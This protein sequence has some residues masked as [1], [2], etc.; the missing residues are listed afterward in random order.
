MRTASAAFALLLLAAPEVCAQS[1][2]GVRAWAGELSLPTTIEG[3][4]NPNPPFD[5]FAVGRFNYPYALRDALTAR[6]HVVRYRALFLEN[7]FLK[8]TVLPELGGH[9]YSCLDKISGREMFYANRSIK[10]RGGPRPAGGT[11][12]PRPSPWRR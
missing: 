2:A 10:A 11:R 8:I 6:Q 12:P 9:L 1:A 4:A 7:E 3:A 5:E